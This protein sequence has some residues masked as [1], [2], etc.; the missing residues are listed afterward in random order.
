[1]REG[2]EALPY[3]AI[4]AACG[5]LAGVDRSRPTGGREARPDADGPRARKA[6]RPHRNRTSCTLRMRAPKPDAAIGPS[7]SA[8]H[9]VRGAGLVQGVQAA[10]EES[11]P[12]EGRTGRRTGTEKRVRFDGTG[13]APEEASKAPGRM[14]RREPNLGIGAPASQ[15]ERQGPGVR[16]RSG[17]CPHGP[18]GR[19]LQSRAATVEAFED[20]RARRPSPTERTSALGGASGNGKRPPSPPVPKSPNP[21][22]LSS[23]SL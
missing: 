17:R 3:G 23:A 11:G 19:L 16:L 1:M 4:G 21:L 14:G 10:S 2:T 15:R 8:P 7:P 22:V 9:G 18:R 6:R 5:F 13:R 20:G 12:P